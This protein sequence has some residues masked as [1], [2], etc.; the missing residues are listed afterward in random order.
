MDILNCLRE[1]TRNA[2]YEL[3]L[4]RTV[5]VQDSNSVIQCVTQDTSTVDIRVTE[6]D[7]GNGEGVGSCN[8]I[9]PLGCNSESPSIATTI[10]HCCLG[11]IGIFDLGLV[12]S[13]AE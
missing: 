6:A 7:S 2:D 11:L 13:A 5:Q 12:L 3:F 10:L 1:Q 9:S 4:G 8:G